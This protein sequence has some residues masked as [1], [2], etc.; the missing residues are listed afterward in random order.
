VQSGVAEHL[1]RR[2]S[3]IGAQVEIQSEDPNAMLQNALNNRSSYQIIIWNILL[4]PDQDIS[5]F[6]SSANTA[7]QGLNLSHLA[8]QAIDQALNE[9]NNATSTD[10][11]LAARKKLS[12]LIENQTPALFLVKPAYSYLVAERI[13]GVQD[14]RVS[15]PSDRFLQ[16][17]NW[18][19]KA[20]WRWN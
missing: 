2:W 1:K 19:V 15:R 9:T 17:N 13:K 16:A 6:W 3:L 14:M 4:S 12:L 20:S 10:K 18:Y 7:G 5:A 11:L 8:S